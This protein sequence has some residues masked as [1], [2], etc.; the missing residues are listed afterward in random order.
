MTQSG[1]ASGWRLLLEQNCPE[2]VEHITERRGV[3]MGAYIR[4]PTWYFRSFGKLL[5]IKTFHWQL[6]RPMSSSSSSSFGW[7]VWSRRR[8]GRRFP[9]EQLNA[10]APTQTQPASTPARS[11]PPTPIVYSRADFAMLYIRKKIEHYKGDSEHR[12]WWLRCRHNAVQWPLPKSNILTTFG[13][14]PLDP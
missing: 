12:L 9:G 3:G 6:S 13:T 14:V 7:Q 8:R 4:T 11:L 1:F 5:L 10:H 2:G